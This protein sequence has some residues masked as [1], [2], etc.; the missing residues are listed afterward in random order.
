MEEAD[1]LCGRVAIMHA[2]KLVALGTPGE[3]KSALAGDKT[4]LDDVFIHYSGGVL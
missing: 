3:L 2:N 4:T 1:H